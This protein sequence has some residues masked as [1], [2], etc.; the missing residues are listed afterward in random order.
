[1]AGPDVD[2]RDMR[3]SPVLTVLATAA[4]AVSLAGSG[5]ARSSAAVSTTAPALRTGLATGTTAGFTTLS[6]AVGGISSR[7]SYQ[8]GVAAP[9]S[10]YATSAAGVDPSL[11]VTLSVASFK[12]D[13]VATARGA[14]DTQLASL[15]ASSPAGT[16][17]AYWHEPEGPTDMPGATDNARAD[18]FTAAA[19]HVALVMKRA[20]PAVRVGVIFTTSLWWRTSG[21]DPQRWLSTAGAGG[22]RVALPIDWI[23]LDGYNSYGIVNGHGTSRQW[24][25]APAVFD[26]SLNWLDVNRPAWGQRVTET[27]ST[28]DPA[29]AGRRAGWIANTWTYLH[30]RGVFSAVYWS[31]NAYDIS[32]DV[33]A[34]HS[35]NVATR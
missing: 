11:G 35:L 22:T 14:Y 25:E 18:A 24:Q 8:G 3:I 10:R 34:K 21:H 29:N 12:S 13:P 9:P 6:A 26:E 30:N 4:V 17:W 31:L 5:A 32:A 28:R 33:A 1:L 23:G 20:N 19:A 2:I 15:A 7:R 27:G 16:A